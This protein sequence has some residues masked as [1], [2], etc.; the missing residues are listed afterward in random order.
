MFHKYLGRSYEMADSYSRNRKRELETTG[1]T[2]LHDAAARGD[3]R[4]VKT[5]LASGTD[6]HVK[7]ARGETPLHRSALRG[8]RE[9]TQA[10][11]KAGAQ[12]NARTRQGDTPLH[13]AAWSGNHENI[14]ALAG[15]GADRNARNSNGQTP[16]D[17]ANARDHKGA[18]KQGFRTAR[19]DKKMAFLDWM[20]DRPAT[21]QQSVAKTSQQ[22]KQEAPEARTAKEMYAQQAAQ[23][24]AAEKTITPAVKTEADR[25]TA[26]LDKASIHQQARNAPDAESGGT[27]SAHLQKQNNQDKSQAALSPTDSFVG[28]T[29]LQEKTPTPQ[30]T[31][32]P[33]KTV[34][35]RPPSW[36]R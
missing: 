17:V 9:T 3:A 23:D 13:L 7:N 11:I 25:A 31:K 33:Q 34:P 8:N 2:M 5:L 1:N 18:M 29:A 12:V 20:K 32:V 35:R 36:E 21:Q 24:K 10:L 22:Q 16:F 28:K 4:A 26:F 15:A 6:V 30:T 27:N 14:S 19:T